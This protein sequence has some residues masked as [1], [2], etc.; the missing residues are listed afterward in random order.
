[1]LARHGGSALIHLK[2]WN[3]ALR[4]QFETDHGVLTDGGNTAP[5]GDC[6]KGCPLDRLGRSPLRLLKE[7]PI[8]TI[9]CG[10]NCCGAEV[11]FVLPTVTTG[12]S[13]GGPSESP[14]A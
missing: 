9:R 2:M 8:F 6:R 5:H 10:C 12:K 7:Q 3:Q 14:H 4:W 11:Q 13:S 1:M